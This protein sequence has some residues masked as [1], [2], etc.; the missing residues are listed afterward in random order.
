[1][2]PA[3]TA[4][5]LVERDHGVGRRLHAGVE[6][7]LR[8][9]N[10][11]GRAVGV[12]LQAEQPAGGFECEFRSRAARLGSAL[13]IRSHGDVDQPRVQLAQPLVTE[14]TGLHHPRV[15]RFDQDVRGGDEPPQPSPVVP[16]TQVEH[17]AA[18]AQRH[19]GPV[20]R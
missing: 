19:G 6:R 11:H 12:A 7:R 8:I 3:P 2:L 1:M 14:T 13:A 9:A 20:Q 15:E 10:R 17:D 16:V 4:L 18:L 5:A